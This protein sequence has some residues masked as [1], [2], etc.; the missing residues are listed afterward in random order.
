MT[1]EDLPPHRIEVRVVGGER[2]VWYPPDQVAGAA[3]YAFR[4]T[5][6]YEAGQ[7]IE[8]VLVEPGQYDYELARFS[9]RDRG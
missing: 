4:L 1:R 5:Q 8:V 2:L 6:I 9:R 3:R 7:D